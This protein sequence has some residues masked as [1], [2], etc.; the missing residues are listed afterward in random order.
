MENEEILLTSQVSLVTYVVTFT[1][2][3]DLVE[4]VNAICYLQRLKDRATHTNMI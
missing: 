4:K 2:K 1:S 3:Y